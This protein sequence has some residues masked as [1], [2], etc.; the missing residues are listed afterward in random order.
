MRP[1][2]K[3]R[4]RRPF[5]KQSSPGKPSLTARVPAHQS[6]SRLLDDNEVGNAQRSGVK[7]N[8]R[9]KFDDIFQVKS[10]CEEFGK[11]DIDNIS[12]DFSVA[13]RLNR[14]E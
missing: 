14:Q 11:V 9:E 7:D 2:A 6:Q 3:T 10:D 1:T 13:A 8:V 5:S 12:N 4:V